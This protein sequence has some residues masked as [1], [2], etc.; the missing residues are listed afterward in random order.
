MYIYMYILPIVHWQINWKMLH[1]QM[2]QVLCRYK[3]SRDN[4]HETSYMGSNDNETL[5][6]GVVIISVGYTG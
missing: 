3:V 4:F 5:C 6:G 2:G 1:R